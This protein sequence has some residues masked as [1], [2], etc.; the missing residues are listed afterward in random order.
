MI[1]ISTFRLPRVMAMI[2]GRK[3][4][5]GEPRVLADD[6][7]S[8]CRPEAIISF[9]RRRRRR[10]VR[11]SDAIDFR[12]LSFSFTGHQPPRRHRRRRFI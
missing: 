2:D 12:F 8:A 1:D 9:S 10:K 7:R 11:Y 6:G 4:G 3:T 5:R